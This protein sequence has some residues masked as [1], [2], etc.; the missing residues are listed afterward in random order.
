MDR[1]PGRLQEILLEII[2]QNKLISETLNEAPQY[3]REL[4]DRFTPFV[5]QA[6]PLFTRTKS[7]PVASIGKLKFHSTTQAH[8][9]FR[10][11]QSDDGS[12]A[13]FALVTHSL[14]GASGLN[15][16]GPEAIK[17]FWMAHKYTIRDGE[18]IIYPSCNFPTIARKTSHTFSMVISGLPSASYAIGD[19]EL[20]VAPCRCWSAEVLAPPKDLQDRVLPSN[21][22]IYHHLRKQWLGNMLV[23]M[24]HNVFLEDTSPE[25]TWPAIDCVEQPK[26]FL[27]AQCSSLKYK[28]SFLQDVITCCVYNAKY[29]YISTMPEKGVLHLF[30]QEV[31]WE[32][33]RKY[34]FREFSG[35]SELSRRENDD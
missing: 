34:P 13:I 2:Q 6:P 19:N 14:S 35:R 10:G 25:D 32:A 27:L 4:R 26:F 1:W 29:D 3:L 7:L 8:P 24:K 30:E 16:D 15:D 28:H 33:C 18:S 22:T 21:I 31:T 20:V 23:V 17:K 9:N 12:F 5:E 11:F